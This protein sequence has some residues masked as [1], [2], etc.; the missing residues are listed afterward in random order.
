MA[1]MVALSACTNS[2]GTPA[3]SG[4]GVAGTPT[5]GKRMETVRIGTLDSVSTVN[6]WSIFSQSG[7][8]FW[9][10]LA[11]ANSYPTLFSLTP[12][13][14]SLIPVL[15]KDLPTDFRQ[16][17]NFYIS[18][19]YLRDNLV[20]SD[21]FPVTAADVAFTI[22]TVLKFQLGFNWGV[23][24]DS[25]ILDHVEAFD[26][27]TVKFFFKEQPGLAKWKYGALQGVIVSQHYW[28][29]LIAPALALLG[30]GMDE[31]SRS[32]AIAT[33]ETLPVQNEPVFGI[34]QAGIWASGS[35]LEIDSNPNAFFSGLL[36][37]QYSN[38]I[39]EEV[40]SDGSFDWKTG[41][42]DAAS[43][44]KLFSYNVGPYFRQVNFMAG[45]SDDSYFTLRKGRTGSSL[46]YSVVVN[47]Y[48]APL[49]VIGQLEAD[50]AIQ[51]S[52]LTNRALTILGFNNNKEIFSGTKGA[53][54]RN[55][56]A[57]MI[58]Q[59]FLAN[60]L[61]QSQGVAA[62]YIVPADNLDWS[63]PQIALPCDGLS[64]PERLQRAIVTLTGEGY[65][66]FDQYPLYDPSSSVEDQII[67]GK[68]L[69][70]A[71]ANYFPN[72]N[73][74]SPTADKNPLGAIAADYI[75]RQ[76]IKLGIPVTVVYKSINER[77]VD[78][79]SGSYDFAIISFGVPHFPNY[80]CSIFNDGSFDNLFGYSSM[81]L[82]SQCGFFSVSN[83]LDSLKTLS[84]NLQIKVAEDL[85][86]V[87]L[88]SNFMIQSYRIEDFSYVTVNTGSLI[89]YEPHPITQIISIQ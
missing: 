18:Y 80:I 23:Y 66:W 74:L 27:H 8:T 41:T 1:V 25:T 72:L 51:T 6:V 59:D 13:G 86:V 36:V 16:E 45:N 10:Q 56:I 84:I 43:A 2:S 62:K 12:I 42:A 29:P 82:K 67:S 52:S 9:N 40:K 33:L 37:T 69:Q 31:A 7:S 32:N 34:Y 58:N 60:S 20:W 81:D 73:I 35:T 57:C 5:P 17:G 85:P 50:S 14:D 26:P 3:D 38:G 65:H 75:A 55:A 71:D 46:V 22:N 19:V 89:L 48:G 70:D 88:Y 15:A 24:Y 21:R 30:E 77:L 44:S 63:N 53:A 4:P 83:D 54:V 47:P 49:G 61:L 28:E 87:P 11:L 39:Y 68:G 78:M 64:D 76:C 79:S